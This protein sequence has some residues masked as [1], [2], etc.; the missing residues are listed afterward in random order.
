MGQRGGK[1]L[2][3]EDGRPETR[4]SDWVHVTSRCRRAVLAVSQLLQP[5]TAGQPF[6]FPRRARGDSRHVHSITCARVST[7]VSIELCMLATCE[8]VCTE[9]TFKTR[10]DESLK[11]L[12]SR[13]DNNE[14]LGSPSLA[15]LFACRLQLELIASVGN[16]FTLMSLS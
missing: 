10:G 3:N 12:T 1:L 11:K 5:A 2:G 13:F 15:C 6:T 14:Q 7:T 4:H 9:S 16:W 8:G